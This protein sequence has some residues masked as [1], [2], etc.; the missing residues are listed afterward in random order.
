MKDF[1]ENSHCDLKWPEEAAAEKPEGMEDPPKGEG[2]AAEGDAAEGGEGEGGGDAAPA[3]GEG[4][5][6]SGGASLKDWGEFASATDVP[7]LLV[8]LCHIHHIFGDAVK[9]ELMQAELGGKADW[10]QTA[11]T[12]MA[13]YL[14]KEMESGAEEESF[15]PANLPEE[16][17]AEVM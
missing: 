15:A 7:K 11:A 12:L 16:D 8:A 2:D 13:A 17:F 3:D 5:P 10:F 1:A 9:V 14:L 6:A 4:A